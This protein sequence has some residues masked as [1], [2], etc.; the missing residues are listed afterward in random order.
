MKITNVFLTLIVASGFLM[1]SC[2]KDLV[3]D[4][5]LQQHEQPINSQIKGGQKTVTFTFGP[6]GSLERGGTQDDVS[7]YNKPDWVDINFSS[8]IDFIALSWTYQGVPGTAVSSLDLMVSVLFRR[9]LPLSL[10]PLH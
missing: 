10:P 5:N 9:V 1:S 3:A 8:S 7:V 2:R 4:A 6:G